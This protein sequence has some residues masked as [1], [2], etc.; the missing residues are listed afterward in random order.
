MAAEHGIK[1]LQ[2]VKN[3]LRDYRVIFDCEDAQKLADT[4]QQMIDERD[5]EITALKQK[6]AALNIELCVY[7]NLNHGSSKDLSQPP[8]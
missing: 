2:T 6:V 7:K 5:Q 3:W 1:T 8:A 4:R